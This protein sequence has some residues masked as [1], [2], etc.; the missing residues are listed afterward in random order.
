MSG[1][2]W[3]IAGIIVTLIVGIPALIVAK[4]VRNNRQNQTVGKGGTGYQAGRDIKI[5]EKP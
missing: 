1:Q 4:K 3:G 5:N 2:E